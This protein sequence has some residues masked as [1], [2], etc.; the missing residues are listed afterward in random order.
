[1][2]PSP[3]TPDITPPDGTD[4]AALHEADQIRLALEALLAQ[5]H[6]FRDDEAAQ[7]AARLHST[8]STVPEI[9]LAPP[10]P[11]DEDIE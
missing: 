1:M 11:Q 10:R 6:R 7:Q 2:H 8:G 9:L 3:G 5:G 4:I